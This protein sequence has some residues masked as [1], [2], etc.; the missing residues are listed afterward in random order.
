MQMGHG[1]PPIQRLRDIDPAFRF[2]L[3]VDVETNQPSDMFTQMHAC[4]ALQ[5]ALYI[6]KNQADCLF[7]FFVDPAPCRP[8]ILSARNVLELATIEGARANG[9]LHKTGTLTP[10]KQADVILLRS[11]QINVA[12]LN[13]EV[14]AV[15]LGMDTSNVDSVFIAGNAVKRHGRLVGVDVERVLR[16][17]EQA[18]E[19]LLAR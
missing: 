15:V 17:A 14:G 12:P 5:R 19:K 6:D 18:R 4:F 9:L 1:M 16:Q 10:G 8:G 11:K 3:S 13:D 2:C 7:Q